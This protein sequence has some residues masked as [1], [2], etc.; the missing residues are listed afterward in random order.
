[1]QKTEKEFHSHQQLKNLKYSQA[2]LQSFGFIHWYHLYLQLSLFSK[3]Y[4]FKGTVS[5]DF[6]PVFYKA[7]N[8]APLNRHKRFPEFF[9]FCEDIRLQSSTTTTRTRDF[10]FRY[11]DFYIFKLLLCIECV[12]KPKYLFGLI[13]PLKS[14][15]K[16][17]KIFPKVSQYS[18]CRVK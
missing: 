14:V 5:R 16:A 6:L 13:V 4:P 2:I 18:H 10:F 17:F 1:M 8:Q 3:D 9:R 7:V 12:N 11:G 15:R